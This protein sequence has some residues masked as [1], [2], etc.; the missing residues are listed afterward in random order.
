MKA[1]MTEP[2]DAHGR[3][4]DFVKSR[5]PELREA[6]IRQY[7]VLARRAVERLQIIPWGCVNRE[8]LLSHAV[9]GLID[10][11]DRFNPEHGVPF[12]GY[13]MPRIR[14]AVLD[15]LR[16]LDWMPRSMR[17]EETKLRRAYGRL[18]AVLGRP[19][20]DAEVAE[21]LGIPV[22]ELERLETDV[23]RSS[24]VS[25]EDLVAGMGENGSSSEDILGSEEADPYRNQVRVEATAR[26]REAIEALPEREK[27]VVSLYYYRELTLKEIGSVLSVSEQRVSQIHARAMTRLSHKLIR[28]GELLASLAG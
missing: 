4:H 10:A 7:A 1:A 6:L 14:G 23:A 12:E 25:L 18:E 8:D 15:A 19:P 5:S 20:S 21:E 22:Q 13:A 26:L 11:V 3:W 24:M 28:H 2:Q 27:L 16:R 9:V 17:A